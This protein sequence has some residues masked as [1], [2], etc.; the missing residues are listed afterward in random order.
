MTERCALC[1]L[2]LDAAAAGDGPDG[3]C[4]SGC[5]AIDRRLDDLPD[6]EGRRGADGPSP[7]DAGATLHTTVDGMHCTACE[8]FLEHR[9][10]SVDGVDA[11]DANYATGTVA[12]GYDPATTDEDD[13]RSALSVAGYD[14]SGS[15]SGAAST[16]RSTTPRLVV[17]AVFG[18]MAMLW[19]GLFLYPHYLG[20]SGDALLLDP[21]GS[22]GTYLFLNLAVV[23]GV[24]V[25]YTGAPILRGALV[26]LRVGVPNADLLL[27]TA[28]LAAY[29]FSVVS[30]LLGRT[31]VYFDVSV[32]VVMAVTLGDHYRRRAASAATDRLAAIAEAGTDAAR[33]ERDGA[34]RR[35]PTDEL[36]ADDVVRLDEGDTVPVDA[37][38]EDGGIAVDESLLTG[39]PTPESKRTGDTVLGGTRVV[40][41]D[42]ARVR[43]AG[44]PGSALDDVTEAVWR[45][46]AG[47]GGVG[48]AVDRLAA[49]FAP[50]VLVLAVLATVIGTVHGGIVGG[51]LAGVSVLVVSCPCAL[52]IATPLAVA[53]G[54]RRAL[55]EDVA[56]VDDAVFEVGDVDV[57]LLD[58]TGTLSRGELA[59]ADA[60]RIGPS[61]RATDGGEPVEADAVSVEDLWGA[62]SAVA[63]RSTHPVARAIASR[64]SPCEEGVAAVDEV[65]GHGVLGTIDGRR[66]A[67]GDGDLFGDEAWR[68]PPALE[69]RRTRAAEEGRTAAY[70]GVDGVA[71]GVV[72]LEQAPREDWRDAV[73]ALDD[74][75]E[76]IVL[77]TGD[78][79]G[80]AG[81]YPDH[82][83][84]DEVYADVRP[85][86]KAALIEE[87]GGTT[88]MVGDGDNDGP[89]LAAADVGVAVGERGALASDA[90]DAVAFGDDLVSV[91]SFLDAVRATRRRT[92]QNLAWALLYNAVGLP[93]AVAGAL[94][95]LAAAAAMSASSLLVVTN[96]M[97]GLEADADETTD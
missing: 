41:G 42:G 65:P 11:A 8:R 82:P 85:E 69:R 79:G 13:V 31:E 29:G 54:V 93:L 87:L 80:A 95:P 43:V 68:V 73:E 17:G 30:L 9:A 38:V 46:D 20:V 32:A 86:G 16:G 28:V 90:A 62:A 63:A 35:V 59:V 60:H 2:P 25:F 34:V 70:V 67:V 26:G 83:A 6:D 15:G 91:P 40:A 55:E 27:A 81:C 76:R 50:L 1:D 12:V 45:A 92:R 66:V 61:E 39:D 52:G 84:V 36:I 7:G 47:S 21:A 49:V 74:H 44:D 10:R 96:S 5:A 37:V 48:R 19:Y 75:V 3:Y 51:M 89:A 22:A 53:A 56:V 14:A 72:V 57:A 24:V 77:V 88:L 23:A 71:E 58:K 64:W 97:R 18:M 94:T 33:V 4:C 78:P